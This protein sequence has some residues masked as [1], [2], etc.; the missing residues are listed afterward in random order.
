MINNHVVSLD[1]AKQLYEAGIKIE[2]EFYWCNDG[3][4]K[5]WYVAHCPNGV[6]Q[7]GLEK[8]WTYPAPL[9]SELGEVLPTWI[10][11]FT[12]S[13]ENKTFCSRIVNHPQKEK[14]FEIAH[15]MPDAMA[16]MAIYLKEK[17]LI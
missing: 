12:F 16:K 9:A 4:S 14:W 17:G 15:T 13:R 7:E 6:S 11:T 8:G 10:V 1:L 3:E 5:H 2:S